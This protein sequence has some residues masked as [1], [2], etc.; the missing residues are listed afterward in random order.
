LEIDGW[1]ISAMNLADGMKRAGVFDWD[2]QQKLYPLMVNLKPRRAAFFQ[3]FVAANQADRADNILSGGKWEQLQQ[4]RADIRD[5]KAKKNL[6]KII[7][8]WV[9]NTERF[10]ELLPGLN[11]SWANLEASIKA[12]AHEVSPSTLYAAAAILENVSRL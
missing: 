12:N 7:V 11:D 8:M 6:E 3:D 5:F 10:S 1:D 4:L 2:L 9:G